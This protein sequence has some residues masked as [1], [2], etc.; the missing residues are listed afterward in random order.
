ML[1]KKP[2][3]QLD[4]FAALAPG[5]AATH[6]VEAAPV[7][8]AAHE[9]VGS[10]PA[11]P[12]GQ[13]VIPPLDAGDEDT[14]RADAAR[15]QELSKWTSGEGISA[16]EVLC[17]MSRWED[18]S[19][20]QHRDMSSAVRTAV[21]VSG[22]SMAAL[23]MTAPSVRAHVVSKPLPDWGDRKR[24]RA[25]VLSLLRRVLERLD[26]ID[27]E[28]IPIA[29]EWDL[30]R[31]RLDQRGRMSL[32]A[33]MRFATF[34]EI[35]PAT[36]RADT[37][38]M[39]RGWLHERTI[40]DKP[41]KLVNAARR[42][43]NQAA[44]TIETWPRTN[45]AL[46]PRR[47]LRTPFSAYL[48]SF[49]EDLDRMRERLS[50][51][52]AEA[53]FGFDQADDEAASGPLPITK[54]LRRATIDTRLQ[55]IRTAADALHRSGIPL[56]QISS[57][58]TLV[59]PYRHARQI[60]ELLWNENGRKKSPT[61]SH[62]AETLRQ[63]GKFHTPVSE[64]DLARLT[65]LAKKSAVR[66]RSM[67][68]KNRTLLE[69]L[70]SP[71]RLLRLLELPRVLFDDAS[72]ETSPRRAAALALRGLV[73]ALLL[74]CPMRLAN[75]LLLEIEAHLVRPDP[76]SRRVA[77][78]IIPAN[79]TKNREPLCYPVPEDLAEFLDLWISHYRDGV[80]APGSPFLIPGLE[81]R[82][83]TRQG[84]RDAVKSV[85]RERV[86]VAIHPHAFRHLAAYLY[87]RARPG[88][89]E[90][91]RQLLG[92]RDLRTTTRAYL[93]FEA[94][95]AFRDFD[96]ILNAEIETL[97]T[98]RAGSRRRR[99]RKPKMHSLLKRGPKPQPLSKILK[100][101]T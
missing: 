13:S 70:N 64:G 14:G 82:P 81:D 83:M 27:K 11:A 94:D 6:I 74:R 96:Q 25:N 54:A 100:G 86:G 18:L 5:V 38:E 90:G 45:L 41:D 59:E 16:V 79:L 22:L 61:I 78:I 47:K 19:T 21:R 32:A 33:F 95:A 48:A 77:A 34:H 93:G 53:L 97:D 72:R 92:H 36:V 56:E 50:G 40:I 8:A 73:I 87:L 67:T 80:A 91:A 52:D 65:D 88:S 30:L 55:H 51:A 29:D 35:A 39:F 10:D 71:E 3:S 84:I 99:A 98:A 2:Y 62:V 66:Y 49:R 85:T 76:A 46:K 68:H 23:M 42:A 31:E 7:T 58:R 63:I 20:S 9:T 43:W 75:L 12:G 60:I 24:R 26:V 1:K 17:Q 4:F 44:Q 101:S 15:D 69:Q 37:L 57:L 89:Y 28:S